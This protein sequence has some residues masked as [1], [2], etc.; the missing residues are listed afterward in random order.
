MERYGYTWEPFEVT[1]EDGYILT[2]FHI[3]GKQGEDPQEL[4]KP[5]I[6]LN[7]GLGDDARRWL[8]HFLFGKPFHLKLVDEGYDVWMSN[9]RGT[10]YSM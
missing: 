6:L 5:P 10:E 9:N 2:T 8:N 1:T 4:T 7:H 3:T